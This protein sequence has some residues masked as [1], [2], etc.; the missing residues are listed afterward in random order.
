MFEFCW[1][2]SKHAA[3]GM[4]PFY[5]DQ[6]Y[7]PNFQIKNEESGE[8]ITSQTAANHTRKLNEITQKLKSIMTLSN[9]TMN[10]YYDTNH[11][12]IEFLV[13]DWV[14]LKTDHIRTLRPCKK[15]T[16]KF[17]GPFKVIEKITNQT[18]R[19]DLKNLV[20]KIHDIFHVEKLEKSKKIQDGQQ[21][22]G[23]EWFVN[24]DE[25]FKYLIEVI[26]SRYS[27]DKIEYQ[28]KYSDKSKEWVDSTEFDKNDIEI[29]AFHNRN[30]DKPYP[31]DRVLDRASRTRQAPIR[32]DFQ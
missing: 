1:N 20:G 26:D 22:Y 5:A 18:Y 2:N 27:K 4:A 23:I 31:S 9:S 15:L 24:D 7:L 16:E 14:M 10:H 6:G 17:I 8:P 32:Y 28:V 12:D 19:L 25:I 29:Q 21:E 30:P 13:G 11:K 3:T